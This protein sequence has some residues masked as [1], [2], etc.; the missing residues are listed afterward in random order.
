MYGIM[1]V[2]FSLVC[3]IFL[4]PGLQS[5]LAKIPALCKS[6]EIVD[7]IT[8]NVVLLDC[9]IIV[10]YNCVYRVCFGLAVFYFLMMIIM[11]KVDSSLDP[12][13]YIQNGFWFFK[14]IIVTALIVGAFYFK[15]PHFDFTWMIFGMMAAF[16]FI[17]IQLVLVVDFAHTWNEKWV[18]NY[19]ETEQ[20]GWY[21]A[22]IFF[23][24]VFYG[25][26]FAG[27]VCLFIYYGSDSECGLNKFFISF[28]MILCVAS[29]I[30]SILPIIQEKMPRSG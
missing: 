28:N 14:Y 1:L 6:S 8:G 3:I 23:T 13:S 30:I 16:V 11:I 27:V 5:I 22:L 4:V 12:R 24:V 15:Y 9:K 20:R 7:A 2:L 19:E 21:I 17:I 26:S 29:S 10:G 25:A 18:E